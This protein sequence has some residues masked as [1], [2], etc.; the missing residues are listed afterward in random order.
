VPAGEQARDRLLDDL[1]VPDDPPAYFL[2]DA[3]ETLT[4]QIDLVSDGRSHTNSRK[5]ELTPDE[6]LQQ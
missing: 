4:K 1:L 5:C 3:N 6:I 2:G